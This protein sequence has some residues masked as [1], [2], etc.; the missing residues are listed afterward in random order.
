MHWQTVALRVIA[1]SAALVACA[2]RRGPDGREAAASPDANW[3]DRQPVIC[4]E[5]RGR[6]LEARTGRPLRLASGALDS[7]TTGV[8]TDSLGAFRIRV[9]PTGP[10]TPASAH[11]RT[12]RVRYLGMHEVRFYVPTLHGLTVEVSLATTALHVDK[13]STVRIKHA[14]FCEPAS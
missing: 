12:V 7:A 6:V 4:E 9:A 11:P 5:V 3:L 1:V 8:A 10:G 14:G 2:G 13:I